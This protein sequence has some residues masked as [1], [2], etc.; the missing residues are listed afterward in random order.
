[1]W[2]TVAHSTFSLERAYDV[3]PDAVFAAWADPV[4]KGR[5]FAGGAETH[6][7]DFRVGGREVTRARLEWRERGTGDWLD[8]LTSELHP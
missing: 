1:V 4:T 5:W 3:P 2:F 7:L 6:Q 8:K